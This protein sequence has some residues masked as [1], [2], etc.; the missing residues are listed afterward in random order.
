MAKL[1]SQEFVEVTQKSNLV[2]DDQLQAAVSAIKERHGGELPDADELADEF[3][4]AGL[5]TKWHSEKLLDKKYKG[6]FLGKYKLLGHL[7][8]GGMSSVYLGEHTLIHR[9]RAIKVLPRSR[10]D[11]SSYL[12]RFKREAQ[13]TA[14]LEHPNIVRAYDADSEGNTHYLVMEYVQGKDLQNVVKESGPLPFDQ[15][16]DYLIQAADGLHFAH[17]N[18]FV[19]RDVKP[20]NLLVDTKGQVKILDLGL[21][22]MADSKV[23]S[24]TIAHNENV[25]GTADYLAPE[26]ALNSHEVDARADIYALGCTLYFL[27]TGHP[28]FP[29]GTLAQRIAKHQTQMP[30][31][32]RDERSD[33]PV[34]LENICFKMLQKRADD[35]YQSMSAVAAALRDWRAGKVE[36][37]E[38][39]AVL[40]G[41]VGGDASRPAGTGGSRGGSDSS[42]PADAPRRT[43]LEDTVSN[44]ASRTELLVLPDS[45]KKRLP[46]ARRIEP[47]ER[48]D[49]VSKGSD[50]GRPAFPKLDL[51]IKTGPGKTDPGI[52]DG[53]RETPKGEATTPGSNKPD[54]SRGET[55]KADSAKIDTAKIDVSKVDSEPSLPR[56]EPPSG[57]FRINVDDKGRGR[58]AEPADRTDP[59]GASREIKV[60]P[61]AGAPAKSGGFAINVGSDRPGQDKG[62][63]AES[64]RVAVAPAE[65]RPAASEGGAEAPVKRPAKKGP[66]W[67][68]LGAVVALVVVA[69]AVIFA[70]QGGSGSSDPDA[71]PKAGS[72]SS[73]FRPSSAW[74]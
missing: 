44:D 31:R 59:K 38:R 57:A 35:R 17:Q 66:P 23:A 61:V 5:I 65:P 12:E 24:L 28:P 69:G 8:T 39:T 60:G 34:S 27:L 43:S 26:Q 11:D 62:V 13:A 42:S 6:F 25:L 56:I 45:D 7:G 32:I 47:S 52:A 48:G 22:L 41:A 71:P 70:L 30:A 53:K 3:I 55:A 15:A 46:V 20:G 68:I 37:A 14:A 49:K 67:V 58:A 1:T 33:C 29:D 19:H 64:G 2:A 72:T 21:A 73:S 40:V 54:S 10:V 51:G 9:Q 36:V 63:K 16:A 18:S 74:D 4:S 50:P